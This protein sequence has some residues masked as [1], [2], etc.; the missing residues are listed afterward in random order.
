MLIEIAS[1]CWLTD[2]DDEKMLGR[3]TVD[4]ADTG[5]DLGLPVDAVSRGGM[6]SLWKFRKN[7]NKLKNIKQQHC[8]SHLNFTTHKVSIPHHYYTTFYRC[9][10]DLLTP[11]HRTLT[12]STIFHPIHTLS[13]PYPPSPFSIPFTANHSTMHHHHHY[14]E[15][16]NHNVLPNLLLPPSISSAFSWQ[17]SEQGAKSSH[18]TPSLVL[19]GGDSMIDDSAW[20]GWV[21]RETILMLGGGFLALLNSCRHTENRF[22][23][24]LE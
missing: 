2:S 5:S 22:C 17:S 4:S 11:S 12:F 6:C 21:E 3:H 24:L 8:Q 7:Q 23:W 14:W 13:R 20:C 10:S 16:P 18:S 19:G 1:I 15:D 9:L